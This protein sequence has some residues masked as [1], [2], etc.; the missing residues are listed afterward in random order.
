MVK[1]TVINSQPTVEEYFD[2]LQ[3]RTAVF[4]YFKKYPNI[5]HLFKY[6]TSLSSKMFLKFSEGRHIFNT[7]SDYRERKSTPLSTR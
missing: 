6:L 4:G 3:N 5:S 7:F 1:C 2:K